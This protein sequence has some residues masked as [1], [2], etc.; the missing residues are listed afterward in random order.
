[1]ENLKEMVNFFI[2]LSVL[3]FCVFSKEAIIF[4]FNF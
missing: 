1:M 4:F 3:L 2:Y